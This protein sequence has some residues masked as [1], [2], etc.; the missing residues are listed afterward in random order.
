MRQP[1]F[2]IS[3]PLITWT[4]VCEFPLKPDAAAGVAYPIPRCNEVVSHEEP[5]MVSGIGGTGACLPERR[6]RSRTGQLTAI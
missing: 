1:V 2:E 3:L 5:E 4:L 6:R